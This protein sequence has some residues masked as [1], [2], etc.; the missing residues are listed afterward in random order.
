MDSKDIDA[1]IKAKKEQTR[2]EL[3][4][5][6]ALLPLALLMFIEASDIETRFTFPLIMFVFILL[7]TSQGASRSVSVSRRE[8]VAIIERQI[9]RDPA[10]LQ[11]LAEKRASRK[12]LA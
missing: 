6:A 5:I 4:G 3:L 2:A 8:L 1:F 10:A 11:L 9:N 12:H 7:V